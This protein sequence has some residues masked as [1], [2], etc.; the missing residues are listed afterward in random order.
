MRRAG[1]VSTYAQGVVALN[2]EQ[3]A[4][5]ARAMLMPWQVRA[6]DCALVKLKDPAAASVVRMAT[7]TGKT[8][9]CAAIIL[10]AGQE[11]VFAVDR[12]ALAEQAA[13]AFREAGLSVALEMGEKRSGRLLPRDVTVTTV[14]TAV[15]RP[16][17]LPDP[18]R[19]G[20]L[21]VD[22][23]HTGIQSEN[24]AALIERYKN[25]RRLALTATPHGPDGTPPLV[26][27]RIWRDTCFDYP[28]AEALD[29]GALVP[30]EA[31]C[32]EL[33]KTQIKVHRTKGPPGAV[34]DGGQ[35]VTEANLHAMA[36]K[37]L[38]MPSPLIAF[39]PSTQVS[40]MFAAVVN[41]YAGKVVARHVDCYSEDHKDGSALEAFR[42]GEY[43]IATNYMI[44]RYGVDVPACVTAMFMQAV[45]RTAYEQGV[46][47][48]SRWCCGASL[49]SRGASCSCG[50]RKDRAFVLDFAGNY[51]RHEG[52]DLWQI[53]APTATAEQRAAMA[54]QSRKEPG[55]SASEIAR[56][57]LERPLVERVEVARFVE[58]RASIGK[59]LGQLAERLR[60]VGIAPK[61]PAEGE[62][63]ATPE[64]L[65][66]LAAR[67]FYPHERALRG[68]PWRQA[69]GTRQAAELLRSLDRRETMG[70]AELQI[71]AQLERMQ[72][73]D[74]AALVTMSQDQAL[75]I[76]QHHR[77]FIT[78]KG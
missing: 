3:A 14:Q 55:K 30:I 58:S 44:W 22:E 1:E 78:K 9:T 27:G 37:A 36:K 57:V 29:D 75:R 61:E 62:Q 64:Q 59:P 17:D 68:G 40:A 49:K 25:S 72:I 65:D 54:D 51:G 11:A 34:A 4:A 42:Q 16:G 10:E 21:V 41:S 33:E 73:L 23:A 52:A 12:R 43:P 69:L 48:V 77:P 7:G 46:G 47:R 24:H 35:L 53:I 70:R 13:G 63:P 60:V 76:F 39:C 71:V 31:V 2:R 56:E 74:K 28:I 5:S 66:E 20:L 26:D 32:V 18:E 45:N 38:D 19:V 6:L 8:R 67:V 50:R 15:A